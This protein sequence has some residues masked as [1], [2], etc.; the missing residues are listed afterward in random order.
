MLWDRAKVIVEANGK[1]R[2]EGRFGDDLTKASALEAEGYAVRHATSQQLKSPKQLMVLGTWIARMM[3]IT[4]PQP[5]EK[6][7]DTL[8]KELVSF[9]YHR[10]S[11]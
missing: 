5:R 9:E 2:H 3:G 6:Q 1:L 8:I 4:G 7:L 10:F 11:L